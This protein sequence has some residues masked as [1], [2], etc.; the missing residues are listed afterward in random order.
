MLL[1]KPK[2][3]RSRRIYYA[4]LERGRC[5]VVVRQR[6]KVSGVHRVWPQ[7]YIF[8]PDG[9]GDFLLRRDEHLQE[10][11]ADHDARGYQWML[12]IARAIGLLID[13]SMAT[14]SAEP[15]EIGKP[16]LERRLLR[17]FAIA[18]RDGTIPL[19]GVDEKKLYWSPR[20]SHRANTYLKYLTYY[21]ECLGRTDDA[22]RW[23]PATSTKN[24]KP[25]PLTAYRLVAAL[26]M[27]KRNALLG[28]LAAKPSQA[29]HRFGGN[30]EPR[31]PSMASVPSFPSSYFAPLLHHGFRDDTAVDETAE[32]LVHLLACFGV[33]QSEPFHL[34][35]SDL[36]FVD[37]KPHIYFF[38]PELSKVT[39]RQGHLVSRR[40][41]LADFGLRPRNAA[42]G[43]LY[44]GWKGMADCVEGV[45]GF[46]LPID[47][48]IERTGILLQRYLLVTR[49]SIMAR[50]PKRASDHPFLLV[51]SGRTAVASGGEIGDPYTVSAF[52]RAWR[53]A[54]RRL[55]IRYDDDSLRVSKKAGTSPHGLRHFYGRFL[56]TAGVEGAVIQR[57][58]HHKSFESHRVYT[59]LTPSE[60]DELLRRHAEGPGRTRSFAAIHESFDNFS[61]P[62]SETDEDQQDD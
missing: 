56:W 18:L 11:F 33:R 58:M 9:R 16:E 21:F 28:H 49:P 37:G 3:S 42:K 39:N 22:S 35:T 53:G 36:Q 60:I 7:L 50:R 40:E 6:T 62:T 38:D 34:F 24:W 25:D 17:A 2:K 41:Y 10:F 48:L 51:S 8:V 44:V 27:R 23:A 26:L 15:E 45:P 31:G 30:V 32:L 52:K 29:S 57:C 61:G 54:I 47:F 43:R 14:L 55:A 59:R 5:F 13:H 20:G 46:N 19:H 4:R 12:D 1:K